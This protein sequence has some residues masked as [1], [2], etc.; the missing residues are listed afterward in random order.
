MR[1]LI[2][3]LLEGEPFVEY[4]TRVDLLG[5]LDNAPDVIDAK[6]RMIEDQKI[7][8]LLQE[9]KDWPGEV[10]NSHKSASQPF[11]KLSFIADI[12]LTKEAQ[13]LT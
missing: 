10:L 7:Q 11:H 2:D 4:R 1:D 5:Q 8:V 3:W 13:T 12:G 6:K 9:L